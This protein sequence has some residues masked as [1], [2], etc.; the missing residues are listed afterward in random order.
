[1]AHK[2]NPPKR[3]PSQGMEAPASQS[4]R[5]RLMPL[6][7]IAAILLLAGC[8]Q[9]APTTPTV[10]AAAT[11]VVGTVQSAAEQAAPT[12]QAARTEVRATLQAGA[13]EIAPTV[14]A[15]QVTADAART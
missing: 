13:T 4:V 8:G 14:Q 1:M 12:V 3:H 7:V 11:L 10:Q 2:S 9:P 6:I 5:L 15:A